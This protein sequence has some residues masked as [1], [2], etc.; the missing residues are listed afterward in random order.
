MK[1]TKKQTA[2]SWLVNEIL[3]KHDK[4]FLEFYSAEIQQAKEMEKEQII[5]A[6]NKGEFNDVMNEDAEQYYT[7]SYETN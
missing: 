7:E 5:N 6:Y 2:V 4:S 3:T 1:A